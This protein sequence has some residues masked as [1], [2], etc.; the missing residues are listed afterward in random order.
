MAACV[1]GRHILHSVR[2]TDAEIEGPGRL[3]L[4]VD[5]VHSV[6]L[7]NIGPLSCEFIAT[8]GLHQY[9]GEN[10]GFDLKS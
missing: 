3:Q 8:I 9:L 4:R 7:G 10:F 1:H 5:L 2:F 6:C